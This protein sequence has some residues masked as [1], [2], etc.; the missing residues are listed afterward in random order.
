MSSSEVNTH[1][2]PTASSNCFSAPSKSRGL[3]PG[4]TLMGLWFVIA[5]QIRCDC[6]QLC[7]ADFRLAKT[8]HEKYAV[9]N[10]RLDRRRRQIASLFQHGRLLSAGSQRCGAGFSGARAVARKAPFVVDLVA[11]FDLS[12]IRRC[13]CGRRKAQ[14][15]QK[16]KRCSYDFGVFHALAFL[17]RFGQMPHF[18]GDRIPLGSTASF[19]VS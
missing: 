2:L 17:I 9:A 6:V 5:R 4:G 13:E 11:F 15:A 12:I 1:P 16:Q 19:T 3:T 18:P 7:I 8:R 14:T 10:E